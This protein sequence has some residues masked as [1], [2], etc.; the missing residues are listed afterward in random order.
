MFSIHGFLRWVYLA[1]LTLAT[2]IF[3]AALLVWTRPQVSP[4]TTLVATLVLVLSLGITAGSFWHTHI[5]GHRPGDNFLYA[6]AL[7]D[8]VLA[9]AVV[10]MTGRAE[11]DFVPLYVLVIAEGALLLP[12]RGGFLVGA[13]TIVLYFADAVWGGELAQR[14]GGAA[15]EPALDA[16]V[17]TRMVLFAVIAAATAWLGDRLRRTGSQLGEVESELRQLRLETSDILGALDTGVVTFDGDGAVIYMNRS[18]ESLLGMDAGRWLGRPALDEMERVAPG[19]GDV[20]RRTLSTGR[21]VPRY[22][23]HTRTDSDVRVLGL[24]TTALERPNRPWVTV[25]MQDITDA[26]QAEVATRRAERLEAV[27]EL[28]ALL[29]HEIKNPLASIRSAVEQLTRPGA[30][31][32]AKDRGVLGELAVGE[33][34]RLSRLLSGF[35]EFSRVELG[36]RAPVD[37]Y[38]VAADV[39]RSVR[40]HPDAGER[41][42]I[43]LTGESVQMEGDPDLLHRAV[44]NLLLNAVQHSP[45]G[46]P[47]RIEVAPVSG[48]SLPAGADFDRGARLRVT[49]RGPGIDPD[50]VARI[51]DPFFTTRPGGTGLGLALVHRAVEA[52]E[53]R[54]F[55]DDGRGTTFTVVFPVRLRQVAQ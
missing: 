52:H 50:A 4:E 38:R 36:E 55:I 14:L 1:R 28:A 48:D 29:A 30:R 3:A 45:D 51:F 23:T 13:L 42:P 19:M 39:A 35:I 24:R 6:Q 26:Q 31:L 37:L 32:G 47:V 12:V 10:H 53:G 27:A 34:E 18:A 5:A 2:G 40:H 49:D 16:S 17:L 7:F 11:S 9:T 21:A 43:E 22:E 54:V 44:F 46:E 20:V 25:V 15:A 33:S 8:V 41:V